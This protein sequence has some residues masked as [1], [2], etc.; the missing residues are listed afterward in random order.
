ML[1]YRQ[2]IIEQLKEQQ[3]NWDTEVAHGKADI[4]ICSLLRQ[5]GY[6]DVV[7]EWDKVDKWYA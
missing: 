5:L 1:T 7:D 6:G 4:I 3:K 2:E